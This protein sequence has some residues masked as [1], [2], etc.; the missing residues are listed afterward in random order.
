MRPV[1]RQHGEER[2]LL[3]LLL[4]LGAAFVIVGLLSWRYPTGALY[5]IVS[6]EPI[7]I[8]RRPDV[9][10]EHLGLRHRARVGGG[11]LLFFGA[12]PSGAASAP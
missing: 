10:R 7:S 11:L 3:G 12:R 4:T 5:I 6:G 8:A 9:G 1:Y 2:T